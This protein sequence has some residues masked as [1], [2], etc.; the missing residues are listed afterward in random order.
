VLSRFCHDFN[1]TF[2]K[3][4]FLSITTRPISPGIDSI[5][6]CDQRVASPLKVVTPAR[7]RLPLILPQA[8]TRPSWQRRVYFFFNDDPA[9]FFPIFFP[10]SLTAVYFGDLYGQLGPT[11]PIGLPSTIARIRRP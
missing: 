2:L 11:S 6:A 7:R 1:F 8:A 3:A 4:G 5:P 9:P 10:V